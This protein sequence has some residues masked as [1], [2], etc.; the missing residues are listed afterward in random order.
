MCGTIVMLLLSLVIFIVGAKMWATIN[1]HLGIAA[2]IDDVICFS[3]VQFI[4]VS[5]FILFIGS[6][7]SSSVL[8]C[9]FAA[10]LHKFNFGLL[11]AIFYTVAG[12]IAIIIVIT[13]PIWF[14]RQ[15]DIMQ[16]FEDSSK[17]SF[18]K[19]IFDVNITET[20]NDY[21]YKF[22]CCGVED[23]KDY[24]KYFGHN[25]SI[26]TSCCN[27]TTLSSVG[28]DCSTIVRKVTDEDISSYYIY[29]KGCPYVIVDKLK[30]NS[31]I[32]HDVGI[33]VTAGSAFVFVSVFTI[34]VSTMIVIPENNNQRCGLIIT[35]FVTLFAIVKVCCCSGGKQ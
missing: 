5:T 13:T 11:I 7:I 18:L 34:F 17:S 29:G 21:Q 25:H 4:T 20:W 33:G 35:V 9:C 10:R 3:C 8:C 14:S 19:Q 23:Y 24:Y 32:I 27:F 22:G 28:I 15:N 2:N 26:P 30:L 12:V 1:G 6:A 31:T 16:R